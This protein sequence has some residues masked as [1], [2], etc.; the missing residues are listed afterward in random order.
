MRGGTSA[1]AKAALFTGRKLCNMPALCAGERIRR[2][3]GS[4]SG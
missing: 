2:G 1:H 3:N 4:K